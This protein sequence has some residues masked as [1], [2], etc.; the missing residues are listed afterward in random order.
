[1]QCA[2]G[3]HHVVD[4]HAGAVLDVADDVHHLGLIGPRTALVDDGEVHV[5]GLGEG[6]GAH[7][8]A[9]VRR[10]HG[11]VLVTL[12]LRVLDQHRRTV[13]VVHGN[14]EEALDLLGVQVHRQQAVDAHRRHHVGHHLGAD[15]YARGTHAAVLAGIAIVGDHGRHPVGGGTV[16]GV[17]H[18]Q[19][20]H[21][22]V[23]GRMAGRLN[24]ED[25]LAAYVLVQF[26]V[27]FAVA[28]AGDVGAPQ[29]N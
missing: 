20:F 4:D 14:A 28:E 26:D 25:V 23:V 22:V 11:E 24:D 15:R 7:H 5:E 10:Y 2:G 18:Q 9:D 27:D 8:A 17:R 12:A 19:Q 1:A 29:G 16:Q 3:V 13:D 6:A 21:Q